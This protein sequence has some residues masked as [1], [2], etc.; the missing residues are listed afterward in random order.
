MGDQPASDFYIMLQVAV[1]NEIIHSSSDIGKPK[2]PVS[3]IRHS[4][5]CQMLPQSMKRI[6]LQVSASLILINEVAINTGS[7]D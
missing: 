2:P 4:N 7:T 1:L 5:V 3:N 6:F